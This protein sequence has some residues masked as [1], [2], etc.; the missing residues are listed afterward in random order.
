MQAY[1]GSILMPFLFLREIADLSYNQNNSSVQLC[2][3][4]HVGIVGA[5]VSLTFSV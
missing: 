3:T 4:L 5:K 2:H 1:N